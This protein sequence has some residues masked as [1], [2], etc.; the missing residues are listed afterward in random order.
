MSIEAGA[1]INQYKIINRLGGGG[2]GEVYLAEDTRLRRKVALKLLS[3]DI[4]KNEDWVLR[5]EQEARAASAL[6]HPN[7]I[8]IYEVGQTEES[9]FISTEFIE[10][11]T[12]RQYLKQNI[13]TTS[14]V[15]EIVIQ[16]SG[17]LVAAHGAGIIHRDIKPEN[18]M[19]RPDGYV[20]VVDFGLAKFTEQPRSAGVSRSDPN[21]ITEA[22]AIEVAV[23]EEVNTNPGMVMGTISYMSPE[24]ATGNEVDARTDVFSLGVLLYEMIAGRLPFEGTSPNEII[25]SI[26]HKKQRPLARF[27]PDT[28]T[29]LERIV[30]KCLSKKRDDRYQSLKD[31]QID[32]RRLKRQLDLKEELVGEP[33]PIA[34]S[35][36]VAS[37][38][39]TQ[40]TSPGGEKISTKEITVERHTSSAEYIVSGIRQHKKVLLIAAAAIILITSATI[41]YMRTRPIDSVVVLPFISSTDDVG[42][43]Y[44]S[45]DTA[46]QIIND[47]SQMPNLRVVPF[48]SVHQYIDR[49]KDPQSIGQELGVHTVL[50]GQIAKR[51]DSIMVSAELIDIRG[52]RQLWGM[53][54]PVKVS[55]FSLVRKE[56]V[57]SVSNAIGIKLNAEEKKKQEAE[58]LYLQGRNAWNKRTANDIN[59]AIKHFN[60]A[61]ELYPGFAPAHAGLADSYNML[62]TYGAKPPKEAFPQARDAAIKALALDNNLAEGHAALAYAT[63]RG[64]WNWPEAE[65]E[66]KQA[67]ALNDGYAS[68]HQW[69]ANLLAAQ[70]R[71]DEA[72]NETRRTQEL[73]KTS[74]IINSHL[75]LVYYFAH[76]YDDAI[77][78]CKKTVALDPTFFVA[79]R[80]LG[81]SYAQKG[82][83][84]EALAAF[85]LAVNASNRSPL[86]RAEHA[87]ALALSGDTTRARAELADLIEISK[88]KYLSAYHLAAIYVA[89]K[90]TDSAFRWLNESIRNRADWLVFLKVDPRFDPL[91][92][93]PRFIEILR[94]IN[95]ES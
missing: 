63:F 88:Q 68:T 20:K 46:Q 54:R 53:H 82:M 14:E 22:N 39:S 2:M 74:L 76:R 16:I 45:E 67:I 43:E 44:L 24:Q 21:A 78:E 65:K 75:G 83:H 62:G 6:N 89:L 32:L 57:N 87:Y 37:H 34:A 52:R 38:V 33:E 51:N 61:L 80:Y 90:D 72:I 77:S 1:S 66:F 3:Q 84:K 30:G 41:Y 50:T 23:N 5:F 92:K 17:A 18:V 70:G 19:L 64:N 27:A 60:Q 49:Q 4:T 13:V 36:T 91:H 95:L 28:P 56:I 94:Q 79:H 58:T 11:V 31:M 93:D 29:E 48:T 86:M 26:I 42:I 10:G 71:F 81:L 9:H 59:E 47:L 73:D 25:A 35:E 85:E 69:Y 40:P 55:D 8:T 12:L 7:I 15:L